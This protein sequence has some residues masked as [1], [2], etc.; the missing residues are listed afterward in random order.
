MARQA[1]K[2]A[3]V[4]PD[5]VGAWTFVRVPFNTEEAYGS[6]ARVPVQGTVNGVAFRSSLMPDGEGGHF[7]VVN[8]SLQRAAHAGPGDTVEVVL[9]LDTALRRV[10]APPDLSDALATDAAAQARFEA[11]PYSHQKEYVDWIE[12]AK[13]AETRTGRIERAL[14]MITDGQ[15]LKG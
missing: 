6:K 9:D 2:A 13:R 11:M 8:K 5:V 7:M 10:E 15:R 14:L 12:S 3:L 4:H 1:F